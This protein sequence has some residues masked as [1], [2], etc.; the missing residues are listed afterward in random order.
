MQKKFGVNIHN[1]GETTQFFGT[2]KQSNIGQFTNDFILKMKTYN[3]AKL[4]YLYFF[5]GI[6]ALQMHF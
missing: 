1:V 3:F 4:T 6:S 5:G 2:Q